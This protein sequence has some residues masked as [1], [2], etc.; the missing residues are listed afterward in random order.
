M[1]TMPPPR[2]LTAA[3]LCGSFLLSSA[4]HAQ[5]TLWTR[6]YDTGRYDFLDDGVRDRFGDLVLS[7]YSSE[8]AG[9]DWAMALT[10]KYGPDGDTVWTRVYDSDYDDVPEGVA[11]D[12]EGDVVVAGWFSGGGVVGSEVL[13]Y[14]RGGGLLWVRLDSADASP[15]LWGVAVDDSMN[16]IVSGMAGWYDHDALL[17][18]LSSQGESLWARTFDFGGDLELFSDVKLDHAGNIVVTGFAGGF[19]IRDL[20]TMKF[21]P[22]GESIW[23]NRLDFGPV[24]GAGSIAVDPSDNIIVVG[25]TGDTWPGPQAGLAVKYAPNGDTLWSKSYRLAYNVYLSGVG[26]S[27][28]HR[29]PR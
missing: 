3:L 29:D 27:K 21:S 23:T 13:K 7:G 24:D 11:V 10:V 9:S 28:A 6:R 4:G 26:R 18:K 19:N 8:F 5:D 16:I 25:S 17:M 12:A 15:M 20:L 2:L 22:A 1:L 14:D